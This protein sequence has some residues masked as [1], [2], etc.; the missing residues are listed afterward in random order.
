[1]TTKTLAELQAERIVNEMTI[2]TNCTKAAAVGYRKILV[3]L[4]QRDELPTD[5]LAE[6]CDIDEEYGAFV[7]S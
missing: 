7:T 5:L 6:L 1:M 4:A 3:T 2:V